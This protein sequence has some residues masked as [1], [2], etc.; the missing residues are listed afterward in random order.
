MPF[1]V[2][3]DELDRVEDG[4]IRA[5][6]QLIRAVADFPN[7]SYVVAYDE[8]RVAQALSRPGDTESGRSY[9]EKI[10]QLQL[11]IPPVFPEE[12]RPLF[13]QELR[14]Q[15]GESRLGWDKWERYEDY[16]D[17]TIPSLISNL[18]DLKRII[19]TYAAIEPM[20]RDE[21]NWVDALAYATILCKASN[22][23]EVVRAK[24]EFLIDDPLDAKAQVMRYDNKISLNERLDRAG[25]S[26][27]TLP[28]ILPLLQFLF[29]VLSDRDDAHHYPDFEIEDSIRKRRP[30]KT[31]LY[32]GTPSGVFPKRNL[33]DF[34]SDKKSVLEKLSAYKQTNKMG[35]FL[36]RFYESYPS[37]ASSEDEEI[38]LNIAEFVRKPNRDWLSAYSEMYSVISSFRDAFGR[39]AKKSP[40]L[41]K[42]CAGI[43]TKI[44]KSEDVNLSPTILR[45][46]IHANGLY[47]WSARGEAIVPSEVVDELVRYQAQRDK[48]AHLKGALLNTLWISSGVFNCLDAGEWDSDC[49]DAATALLN[50]PEGV[51]GLALLFFG[52]GNTTELETLDRIIDLQSFLIQAKKILATDQE[53]DSSCQAALTALLETE[54]WS[55]RYKAQNRNNK[56]N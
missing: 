16:L 2:F 43:L 40:E 37:L 4:E 7:I 53:L 36:D 27:K 51:A 6:A 22:I 47:G 49:R 54:E 5:V 15:H 48:A 44:A 24:A 21:V 19:Q 18:R 56:P 20:T 8:K 29:P 28:T 33:K 55:I 17:I 50:R 52:G 41:S 32:L 46:E 13:T 9:L 12:L 26:K 14:K 35:E 42:S 23:A 38:W 39:A 1:V 3:I 34:L 11:Q 25:F 45:R 10:I 31:L 30:I